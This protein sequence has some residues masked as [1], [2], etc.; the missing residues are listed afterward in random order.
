MKGKVKWWNETKGYGFV[1]SEEGE[2]IFVHYS[3]I[4]NEGFKTLIEG[5]DVTFDREA[6]PKGP[7]AVNLYRLGKKIPK[8]RGYLRSLIMSL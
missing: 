8:R 2:D 4:Q 3:Y 6:G 1:T 7:K 5:E